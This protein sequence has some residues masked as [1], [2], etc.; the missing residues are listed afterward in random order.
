[1]LAVNDTSCLPRSNIYPGVESV[2][3]FIS[4][5][6]LCHGVRKFVLNVL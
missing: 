2:N 1:M 6:H 5:S 4:A 3:A